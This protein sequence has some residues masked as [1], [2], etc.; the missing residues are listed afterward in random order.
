LSKIIE[1]NLNT[2]KKGD[3]IFIGEENKMGVYEDILQ[4]HE[5]LVDFGSTIQ[6]VSAKKMENESHVEANVYTAFYKIFANAITLHRSILSLCEAGWTHITAILVRTILECSANCLA[7]VNNELPEYM[8]F[9]FLYHP[10]IQIVKDTKFPEEKRG[11]AKIE[12]EQGINNLKDKTIRQK[13]TEF[14]NIDK[15][16]VFWFK[17]EENGVSSII[18][19]Y[20]GGELK[21]LYGSLSMSTHAGHLGMFLFKDNSDDININPVENPEKTKL[22]LLLS[23]RLLLE[24][25]YIRIVYE[26][27]DFITDYDNFF[28]RILAFEDYV[29]R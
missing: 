8:A 12:L 7:I 23:C 1:I 22:V 19:K 27:L 16:D 2:E 6:S 15:L 25:F 17:P 29:K 26:E 11:K 14:K 28:K 5:D 10:F 20:G 21:F 24:L 4:L 3:R 9:K 18:D 13:A